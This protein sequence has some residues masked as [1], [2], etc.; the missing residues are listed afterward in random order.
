MLHIST[1]VKS[2]NSNDM[3]LHLKT[4]FSDTFKTNYI[5]RYV[6]IKIILYCIII[7]VTSFLIN[8]LCLKWR[9]SRNGK[10]PFWLYL[11]FFGDN[12]KQ[13]KAKKIT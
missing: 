5:G 2:Q 6:P 3:T 7:L 9:C 11:V 1:K 13:I 4:K 8:K 12:E 10:M